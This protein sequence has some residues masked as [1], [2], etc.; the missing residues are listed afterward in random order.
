V[1][2]V[3]E[4]VRV[5]LAASA[6]VLPRLGLTRLMATLL[7]GVQPFDPITFAA[8]AAGLTAIALLASWLPAWKAT[9][10]HPVEALRWE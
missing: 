1:A 2:A 4:S 8:V 3:P 7:Y 9:R 5:S 6:P 10:V